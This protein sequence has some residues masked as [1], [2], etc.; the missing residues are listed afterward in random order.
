MQRVMRL[1]LLVAAVVHYTPR[2]SIA[3]ESGL[4]ALA[5]LEK[6]LLPLLS[7]RCASFLAYLLHFLICHLYV[8][9]PTNGSDELL[10]AVC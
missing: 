4:V 3:Y 6:V 1:R 5:S 8:Q 2:S 10:S 7:K 9:F